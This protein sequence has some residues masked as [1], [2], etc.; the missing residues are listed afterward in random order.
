MDN[1]KI[2]KDFINS[3]LEKREAPVH[4]LL[5]EDEKCLKYIIEKDLKDGFPLC[6][7]NKDSLGPLEDVVYTVKFLIDEKLVEEITKHS[8]AMPDFGEAQKDIDR[9]KWI[10]EEFKKIYGLMLRVKPG[11]FEYKERGYRTEKQKQEQNKFWLNIL[12]IVIAGI[13]GYFLPKIWKI[14]GQIIS[15]LLNRF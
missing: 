7:Y 4:Y 15:I 12:Y 6:K 10:E 11:L 5:G 1:M 3:L 13:F 8:V 14:L 2:D 9:F